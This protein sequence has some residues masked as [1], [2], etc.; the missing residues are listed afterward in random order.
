MMGKFA[1]LTGQRFGRLLVLEYIGSQI[2]PH[3]QKY[4]SLWLCKCDCG[5]TKIIRGANMLSG[6][7][8]SCGCLMREHQTPK[9]FKDLTGQRFGRLLVTGRATNL[10]YPNGVITTRFKCLCDCG[11]TVVVNRTN[12]TSGNTKSCGCYRKELA[13]EH[14]RQMRKECLRKAVAT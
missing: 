12:L 7:T 10:T 4:L 11:N 13:K 6:A 8:R 9:P 5:T 14:M 2:A 1:D 3:K